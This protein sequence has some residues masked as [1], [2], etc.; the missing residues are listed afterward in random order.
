M[1]WSILRIDSLL[2]YPS[3]GPLRKQDIL[4][5][6]ASELTS[7]DRLIR[8]RRSTDSVTES[9]A[10]IGPSS[11]ELTAPVRNLPHLN[12]VLRGY[13]SLSM[14]GSVRRTG[15]GVQKVA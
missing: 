2:N 4:R 9:V 3:S 11:P 1:A 8:S 7:V 13:A 10:D 5:P 14:A 6:T 12:T 15:T